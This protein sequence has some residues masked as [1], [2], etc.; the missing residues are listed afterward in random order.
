M[1]FNGKRAFDIGLGGCSFGWGGGRRCKRGLGEF[2]V[3]LGRLAGGLG[4][5]PV[6]EVWG[7]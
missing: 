4:G 3:G 7:L 2:A 1:V 6:A 5:L